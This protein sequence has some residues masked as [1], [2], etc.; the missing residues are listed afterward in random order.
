MIWN[1][2]VFENS[3]A[4]IC[5]LRVKVY[6]PCYDTY[7]SCVCYSFT[8][9]AMFTISDMNAHAFNLCLSESTAENT[10]V[11]TL[12]NYRDCYVPFAI[13]IMSTMFT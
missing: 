8:N 10:V 1:S 11:Y 2:G 13:I 7:Y 3:T 12:Y 9:K 5:Y 4:V 6:F